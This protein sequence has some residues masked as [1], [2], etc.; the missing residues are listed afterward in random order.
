MAFPGPILLEDKFSLPPK[1]LL[2]FL[3]KTYEHVNIINFSNWIVC[4]IMEK[5]RLFPIKQNKM[6][7]HI[8]KDKIRHLCHPICI[9]T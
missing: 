7:I 8:E 2:Y 6:I 3:D 9:K 5:E 1:S 4:Q